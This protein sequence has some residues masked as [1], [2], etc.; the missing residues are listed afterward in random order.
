M[1]KTILFLMFGLL[2][3]NLSFGAFHKIGNTVS[4]NS[5][6]N[7]RFRHYYKDQKPFT[8]CNSRY[9]LSADAYTNYRNDDNGNPVLANLTLW[10][11]NK[12][13]ISVIA[14]LNDDNGYNLSNTKTYDG[15]ADKYT[16]GLHINPI[17]KGYIARANAY[18]QWSD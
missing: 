2:M 7:V 13:K 18:F 16:I 17:P 6:E 15:Y 14:W 9:Y 12:Q 1:K 3:S 10:H 4:V 8:G 11:G 5:T